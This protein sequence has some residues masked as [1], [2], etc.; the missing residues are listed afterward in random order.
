M[1]LWSRR[2]FVAA[3]PAVLFAPALLLRRVAPIRI[4]MFHRPEF[5]NAARAAEMSAAEAQRAAA[6]LN[7]E[8]HFQL[9]PNDARGPKNDAWTGIIAAAPLA[10]VTG[11]TPVID[12]AGT[13]CGGNVLTLRSPACKDGCVLWHSSLERFGAGQLNDRF[14]A[15]GVTI[16]EQA[17]LGWFAVKVLWE[18]G[19]RDKHPR[20]LSYDGHKGTALRF[21][22]HGVLVQPLYRLN[23]DRTSI[24]YEIKPPPD[25]EDLRCR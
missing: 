12:I 22:Q 7:R 8:L 6:L 18:A 9:L 17:W 4:A 23:A 11:E 5:A 2:E 15:A 1:T 20:D 21:N 14:K 16:D 10:F 3:A 19:V 13:G 24:A 25:G